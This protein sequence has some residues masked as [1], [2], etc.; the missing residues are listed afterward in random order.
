MTLHEN[1]AR[2]NR[3]ETKKYDNLLR[4]L[5]F[6]PPS[7]TM[8]LCSTTAASASPSHTSVHHL[9]VRSTVVTAAAA[10]GLRFRVSVCVCRSPVNWPWLRRI[11]SVL[12]SAPKPVK[13]TYFAPFPR[14]MCV[15]VCVCSFE[16]IAICVINTLLLLLQ[17]VF[18]HFLCS[19]YDTTQR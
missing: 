16:C 12:K 6:P 10:A 15:C 1:A 3:N 8:L 17:R 2:V 19:V 5:T 14:V 9:L 13:R 7:Q 4:P 18:F 11:L